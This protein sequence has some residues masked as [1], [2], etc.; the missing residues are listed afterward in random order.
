VAFLAL[1]TSDANAETLDDFNG[2]PKWS[3]E[4][5]PTG[6][7]TNL[8]ADQQLRFSADFKNHPTL[9]ENPVN[10]FGN[11]YY[12]RNLPLRKR[13]TLELRVDLVSAN[14]DN[15][16]ACLGTMSASG[17]EYVI[18]KD[19]NEIAL[20][21]WSQKDGFSAAFWET[22]QVKNQDVVLVLTLT[23]ISDNLLVGTKIL[24]KA[25]G[26]VLFDRIVLDG[27]G[28]DWEVPDRAPQVWQ[29]LKPDVGRPYLDDLTVVWAAIHHVTDGQQG[30]AEL[31]LDNLE[32][33][34]YRSAHL[35]L[36]MAARLLLVKPLPELR[37]DLAFHPPQGRSPSPI[38]WRRSQARPEGKPGQ[39]T[40]AFGLD[41]L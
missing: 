22:R 30:L 9:P 35:S 19:Q 2:P 3:G 8:V 37:P 26:N 15:L 34:M 10:T 38:R 28:V 7:V 18:L 23:P 21:K 31:R 32:Y 40:P 6:L 41:D 11:I 25:S 33:D 12:Q 1:A 14:Q 36:D 17:G 39:P 13:Q 5:D 24:E 20:L 29:V 4:N 16:F 27:P